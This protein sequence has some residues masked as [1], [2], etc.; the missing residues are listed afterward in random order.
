MGFDRK[1]IRI[2]GTCAY[3]INLAFAIWDF[4]SAHKVFSRAAPAS[5]RAPQHRKSYSNG[6][7]RV[8]FYEPVRVVD[9][10]ADAR[11]VAYFSPRGGDTARVEYARLGA[12]GVS[13][14]RACCNSNG[15]LSERQVS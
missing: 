5:S 13:R 3:E 9:R 12:L 4:V 1:Q 10:A 14:P 2:S 7:H 15:Y 8:N 11:P 6:S